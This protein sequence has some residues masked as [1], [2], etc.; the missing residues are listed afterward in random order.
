[1]RRVKPPQGQAICTRH[2]LAR[3]VCQGRVFVKQ[4]QF[5]IHSH[6]MDSNIVAAKQRFD[7]VEAE[8]QTIKLHKPA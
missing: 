7:L 2:G 1:M 4:N 6:G 5:I 3:K 8:T